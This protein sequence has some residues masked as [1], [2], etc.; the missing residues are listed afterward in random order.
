MALT[1]EFALALGEVAGVEPFLGS[2][3]VPQPGVTRIM[4][5]V[6]ENTGCKCHLLR[7]STIQ[8]TGEQPLAKTIYR[9]GLMKTIR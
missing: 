3:A 9:I 7:E 6:E 8:G 4:R 2:G 1:I 5:L